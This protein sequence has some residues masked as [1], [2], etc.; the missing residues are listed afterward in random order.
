[1]FALEDKVIILA[2]EFGGLKGTVKSRTYGKHHWIYS[3]HIETERT[4]VLVLDKHLARERD[5][6][7]E[8]AHDNAA[9]D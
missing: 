8:P 3:I 9:I 5:I 1:M 2:G 4:P 7:K 6:E